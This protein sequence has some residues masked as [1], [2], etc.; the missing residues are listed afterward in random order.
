MAREFRYVG[1]ETPRLAGR[2]FVTGNAKYAKDLRIPRMLHAKVL[3]SPYAYA[4]ILEI[5]TEDAEKLP[6]V[7]AVLTYRNTPEWKQGMPI[8]HKR[9]L[10]DTVRFVGDAVALV[11][12]ER[13]DVAE[14]AVD[15]IRVK[16]EPLKP[17]FGIRDAFAEDAPQLY[18]EL[19]GNC[20]PGEMFARLQYG[21]TSM[22]YGD[23]EQ[24]F[25]EADV[26]IENTTSLESGQNPMPPEPP[27]VIAEWDGSDLVVRGS[28]SSAGLCKLL[29]AP[30]MQLPISGMRVI[31]AYVGASYGSKHFSGC[32]NVVF[33]TAALSKA[34]NRPVGL[35]YTKEE[36]LAAQT[37]RL[38]S[39]A[40]YKIGLKK[41]GTITAVDGEWL[42]DC[43]SFGSEQGLMVAVGLISVPIC[44]NSKNVRVNTKMV[45]TNKIASG[46][47]RGYGYLE[48][49]VHI[50]NTLY[51]G[52]EQIDIDPVEYFKK[53]RIKVGDDIFHAYMC[54][55]MEK[56][57]GPDNIHAIEEGAKS[58]G[59]ED[60]W[61]GWG[62]NRIGADGRIHAVG[63]GLSGHSDV[64]EQASNE[65]VEL[66]FD[67]HVLIHAGL[68]EFG[69][70]GRDVIRKMVAEV[71]N[72]PIEN[73]R[74]SPV[75]TQA[76]PYEWG[77]TGSRTT[78]AV[79]CCVVEAAQK[80]RQELLERSAAV[81]QCPV[82]LLDTKDGLVFMKDNPNVQLPWIAPIGFNGSIMGV[83]HF[84]GLYTS[85]MYQIQ[86]VEIALDPGTGKIEVVEL[87]SAGECGQ[88]V[89]PL[90]LK[91]Q[92]DGY[93]PGID[94]ALREETVWDHDGRILN[95]NMIEY[96]TRTF[97]EMPRHYNIITENPPDTDP[98]APCG[99]IGA[100]EPSLALGI[101]AVTLAIYNA[102]GKWFNKYPI[103]PAD[104]LAALKERGGKNG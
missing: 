87:V 43:G 92:F 68:S 41:D 67:G 26:I 59:W 101:P 93:F 2:D 88:I 35:F 64:G 97:N 17:V 5:D 69:T 8:Q 36:Q 103:T 24:G 53:N 57:T 29:N 84:K 22:E 90:A 42:A 91:G 33:Y 44:A 63:M 65:N 79:G 104:I 25:S 60:R 37:N 46:A 45:V 30:Q 72:V 48:H 10:D 3:R 89:N 55:G 58:F 15:L 96:K 71:I 50:C 99:A 39:Q 77:S 19:P 49:C 21:F 51:R 62:K 7:K 74:V 20:L 32:G 14:E 56:A 52:L 78:F 28:F 73:V 13:E 83:G 102:T 40:H 4:K 66:E 31:P 54:I 12:A 70:G 1:K 11:A 6:G 86:F 80:A 16:Y 47:Y 34:T 82:A 100:G 76:N 98:A 95:P 9:F 85:Q 61:L 27:G 38:N 18:P 23:V 94:L 81:L 75:D